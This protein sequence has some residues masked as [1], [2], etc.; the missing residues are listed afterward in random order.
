MHAGIRTVVA[1]GIDETH[2]ALIMVIDMPLGASETPLSDPSL[3]AAVIAA[4][5]MGMGMRF[6]CA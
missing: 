5:C 4:A 3:T 1:E 6:A 2:W